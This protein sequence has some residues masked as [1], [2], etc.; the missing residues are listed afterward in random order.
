MCVF[1]ADKAVAWQDAT[2]ISASANLSQLASFQHG[3]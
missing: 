1:L 3:F 2:S